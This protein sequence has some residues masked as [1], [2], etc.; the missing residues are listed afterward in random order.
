MADWLNGASFRLLLGAGAL[1]FVSLTTVG[2][3]ASLAI[4]RA[5][6]ARGFTIY[7]MKLKQG[8]RAAELY[9]NAMFHAVWVLAFAFAL[10]S[11]WVRFGT[12][13]AAEVATFFAAWFGFQIY[14][15]FVHRAMHTRTLFW[16]HHWH[17]ESLVP[18]PLSGFSMGPAEALA[19][20]AGFLLPAMAMTRYW[21]VGAW[22][23]LAFFVVAFL[24]N[25]GSHANAE[26]VP[27]SWFAASRLSHPI[28]FHAIHHARFDGH[29]GFGASLMD[30]L[31]GTEWLDWRD[32]HE[33]VRAG[34][35]LRSLAAQGVPVRR[36]PTTTADELPH[37]AEVALPAKE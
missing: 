24:H 23:W 22:G 11:G 19:W 14:Y 8:Q 34:E 18:T 30:W 20:S 13:L 10:S 4:E 7:A 31:M 36:S 17:H 28:V 27:S 25:I 3:L 26:L 32:T 16:M 2:V 5:A 6:Q 33:Q 37:G 29:Y 12:S 1:F 15:W 21:E 9:G 35:A